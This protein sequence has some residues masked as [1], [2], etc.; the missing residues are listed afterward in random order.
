MDLRPL[1][2]LIVRVNEYCNMSVEHRICPGVLS[3]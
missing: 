1:N 3:K 2:S